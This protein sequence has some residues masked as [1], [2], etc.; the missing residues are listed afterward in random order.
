MP[1]P[2]ERI[3]SINNQSA[4]FNK[5]ARVANRRLGFGGG[6]TAGQKLQAGGAAIAAKKKTKDAADAA[7]IGGRTFAGETG[8]EAVERRGAGFANVRPEQVPLTRVQRGNQSRSIGIIGAVNEGV[9]TRGGL[10][11]N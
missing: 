6:Q 3:I 1:R 7:G 2:G 9:R 11:I 5:L 10:S 4:K 8:F